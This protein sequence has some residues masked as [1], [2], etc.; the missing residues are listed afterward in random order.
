L[1]SRPAAVHEPNRSQVHLTP[2]SYRIT[3]SLTLALAGGHIMRR[4]A[5]TLVCC[6]LPI[7]LAMAAED[8]PK[9]LWPS[10][11]SGSVEIY[12]LNA[13]G[14]GAKKLTDS[15]DRNIHP[16]WS[17]DGKRI[18][19]VSF[20]PNRDR[21]WDIHVMDGDGSNVKQ[22]TR[23]TADNIMPAWSPDGKK[24]A[25]ASNREGRWNAIFVMNPDGSEQKN[26]TSIA[27]VRA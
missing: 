9:L 2:D 3:S 15:D 13:D 4:R 1:P 16:A 6:T 24:I 22:L 25:F 18:A 12:L 14:S 8:T 17:P 20:V 7:L 23:D 21:P 19:F 10:E 5:A 26:L 11:R 27:L